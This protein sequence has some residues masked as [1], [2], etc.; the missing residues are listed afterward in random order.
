M[1]NRE[2]LQEEY[3]ATVLMKKM[4]RVAK[5][6]GMKTVFAVMILYYASFDEAIPLKER[7]MILAALGYFILPMDLIPDALPM[8]FTDDMAAL[9]YILKHVWGHLTP[10]TLLKAKAKVR[11]IFGDVDEGELTIPG[12]GKL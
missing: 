2:R 5:A 3:S 1:R 9:V 4:A 10:S 6:A 11:D 7:M 8:G 12:L